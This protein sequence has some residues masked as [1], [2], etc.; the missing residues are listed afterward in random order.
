MQTNTG[1]ETWLSDSVPEIPILLQP[2]AP[3]LTQST[4]E[5]TAYLEILKRHRK[6]TLNHQGR[7]DKKKLLHCFGP[8][9]SCHRTLSKTCWAVIGNVECGESGKLKGLE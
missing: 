9:L 8:L 4:K 7:S 6:K 3:A 2:V 1:M 5:G